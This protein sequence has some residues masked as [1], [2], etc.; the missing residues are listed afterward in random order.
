M[1]TDG[2]CAEDEVPCG[3]S[4]P[5]RCIS[6]R[7]SCDGKYDCYDASDE[8]NCHNATCHQDDFQCVADRRCIR[9]Q[10]RCDGDRDCSDGS[11]EHECKHP[12]V[13]LHTLLSIEATSIRLVFL[14]GE[15]A[16]FWT[17]ILLV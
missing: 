4:G 9:S 7:W 14:H 17:C 13:A 12:S 15:N 3:S 1:I 8:Q 5:R 2:G 10:Y 11:D 16:F 6:R